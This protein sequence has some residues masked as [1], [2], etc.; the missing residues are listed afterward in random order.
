MKD[1]I[2]NI[3]LFDQI[4]VAQN[5]AFGIDV[6]N[7]IL[8]DALSRGQQRRNNLKTRN[9]EDDDVENGSNGIAH[10]TRKA[11]AAES[12]YHDKARAYYSGKGSKDEAERA[13]K[14]MSQ[15]DKRINAKRK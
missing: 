13:L 15:L 3:E 7:G 14:S 6:E 12:D 4:Q 1:F 2:A 9:E 10:L 8:A 11:N 5:A